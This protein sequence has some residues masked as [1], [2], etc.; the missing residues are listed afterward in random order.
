MFEN[1]NY[2]IA[3]V[4]SLAILLGWQMLIV[5]PR[6][7]EQRKQ[8]EIAQ[9][10][11][12][13]K[14]PAPEA[15]QSTAPSAYVVPTPGADQGVAPAPAAGNGT[16]AATAMT[17][18]QALAAT[19]RVEI[20]TESLSGSI[21]LRGARIDDIHLVKYH[22]TVDDSSPTI[23]LF[24]PS[25]SEHPYYAEFDWAGD[26]AAKIALPDSRTVWTQ[27][28]SGALTEDNPLELSWE[29]GAGLVFHRTIALDKDY[30]FTV[31]Q[32]VENTTGNAVNL[33]P[34]GLISH[35]GTPKTAGFYILHEG[36]IGVFGDEGLKE[37]KYKDLKEDKTVRGSKI[38][39]GWLGITD[40]YW[41]AALLPETVDGD[42]QPRFS[43]IPSV[44]G[45]QAD[46]L[47]DAITIPAG[48]SSEAKARLFAGAKEVALINKY[49]D[50][51]NLHNFDLM[52][53]W[54][55]FYFITKPM[56][57]MIDWFYKL[58][59][60]FGIAILLATVVVK[61]IFFP[62]A[63][64]SYVSMSR[65]KKV[66]PQMAEIRER[67]KDDKVQQQKAMMELYKTEKI[68][69]LAGC[70]PV[71]IQIPVFFSLY[72]VLYITI[73]MRHA[74]F[75]GWIQDLSAPDPTSVFTLFGYLAWDAPHFLMI[76]IWPIIMGITMFFQM[77]MN[78]TP[79]EPAQQVIFNWMPVLFTFML[80]SFPA[81]LVIYWAWNNTLS[82]LQQ[83][84]IM[85]RQSVEVD[86]FGNVAGTFK[87]KKNAPEKS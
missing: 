60:N 5:Q 40:K 79:A 7:E 2:I 57:H 6:V 82:I 62:L 55:W 49:E 75:F 53:D 15:G 41:A 80:G 43:Y 61:L 30:M 34:Y 10:A 74:S 18:D 1:K 8:Q 29:N 16:Q 32:S 45:Y 36:L 12:A 52:I 77:K 86:L 38:K 48:G 51:Y 26:P 21:N 54:G 73:E 56:F 63:N 65:M 42:F 68:N 19:P 84:V 20:K 35:H 64:K 33:Y 14:E 27:T 81:G 17:R 50:Q 66:Q 39:D 76:G 25:G 3:I 83:Y 69:P 46:F 44:D 78:P 67:Y 23:T 72:K 71:V 28:N 85:R 22:E 4:L 31:T 9:Q 87:R 59:G 70:L 58:V 11:D 24:S 37:V 47:G 13:A